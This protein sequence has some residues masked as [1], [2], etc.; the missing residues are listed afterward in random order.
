V[1]DIEN[2][3]KLSIRGVSIG[4]TRYF[5][6][7]S[8]KKYMVGS[9]LGNGFRVLKIEVDKIIL[10]YEGSEITIFYNDGSENNIN[11]I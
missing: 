11:T 3:L 1:T 6:S 5:T 9:D 10:L 8:G 7:T 2:N 4:K